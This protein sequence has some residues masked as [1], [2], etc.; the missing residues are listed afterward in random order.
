MAPGKQSPELLLPAG[1]HPPYLQQLPWLLVTSAGKLAPGLPL[2]KVMVPHSCSATV[3]PSWSLYPTN[4]PRTPT[5]QRI[6]S[7]VPLAATVAPG[8]LTSKQAPGLL[9]PSGFVLPWLQQLLWLLEAGTWQA[10]P[11]TPTGLDPP[12]LQPLPWLL[13][14]HTPTQVDPR[15]SA[16]LWA[17]DDSSLPGHPQL[18]T[19]FQEPTAT[20]ATQWSS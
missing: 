9:L 10:V 14:V 15:A 5:A 17:T 8:S 1:L 3:L 19:H 7:L 11:W 18:A 20:H 13:E 6:G 4:R 2:P 12:C 16:A